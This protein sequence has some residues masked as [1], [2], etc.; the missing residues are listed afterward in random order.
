MLEKFKKRIKALK[1]EKEIIQIEFKKGNIF[2]ADDIIAKAKKIELIRE[3][4]WTLE[5]AIHS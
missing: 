5:E 3:K 4:I 2:S 1:K